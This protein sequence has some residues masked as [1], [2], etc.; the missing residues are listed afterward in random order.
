M[1][2]NALLNALAGLAIAAAM[3]AGMQESYAQGYITPPVSVSKEKVRINGKVCYSHIVKEKQTL[4][5]IAKA[6]DVS[7]EDIYAFNPSIKE[8]GL[9]KNSIILIPSKDGGE[10]KPQQQTENRDTVA[11]AAPQNSEQAKPAEV[12]KP[13]NPSKKQQQKQKIHVVK[14]YEDL[15]VI[16]GKYGVSVEDIMKANNLSGRKLSKRQK[17]VIPAPG[18][19]DTEGTVME[20]PEEDTPTSPEISETADTTEVEPEDTPLWIFQPKEEVKATLILPLRA[21]SDNVS[22]NNMDFYSGVLMA[23]KDLG[24]SGISTELNVYDT[25]DSSN[26]VAGEDIN[27]SD[28]VIGPVS[29]GD[30]ERLFSSDVH[31]RM[32]ISPL[33]PRAEVLTEVYDNLIQAPTPQSTIYNDLVEWIKED[34]TPG[35]TLVLISEKGAR[36]ND[37]INQ[38]K[39]I[40]DSSGLNFHTFSYS[41][42]EGR[43]VI[44]PLTDMMTATGANRVMIASDSEAFINDVVRNLNILIY[45]K[46]N[47]VLYAPA[48]IRSFETIEIENL[49]NLSAHV[50][51]GY[52]IDYEEPAVKKFLMEYRALFNTEPSQYAFQGY[53]I[54]TYFVKMCNKY[55]NRWS[56]KLETSPSS[57]LQS[58]FDCR[59]N[60]DEGYVNTGVRRI[61]YEKGWAIRKVQ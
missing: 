12:S 15:D 6:Y 36:T 4:Y 7:I 47:V 20:I 14:W 16:A 54:A 5:S 60:D 22:R 30:L 28:L 46:M 17:L 37:A 57:M 43:D 61:V 32:V 1:K 56:R 34:I 3:A 18:E 59:K 13:S 58:T 49:H 9:K 35:D 53:D 39:Q 44:R 21:S 42:L 25:Y 23:L 2:Q 52:Y 19:Y 51:L 26:P 55:G 40:A 38:I 48:R 24:E 8:T 41:I 31:P 10:Q 29:A 45:N 50:S 27:D 33:D 11:T